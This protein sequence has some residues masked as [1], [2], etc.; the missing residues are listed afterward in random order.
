M[1]R[2]TTRVGEGDAGDRR[3]RAGAGSDGRTVAY[4]VL[5]GP[6]SLFRPPRDGSRR[7]TGGWGILIAS[8]VTTVVRADR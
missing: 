3:S 1:Q 5:A 6:T 8:V 7:L 2:R 4:L